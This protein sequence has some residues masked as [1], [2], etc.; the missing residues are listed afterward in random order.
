MNIFKNFPTELSQVNDPEQ[1]LEF[2]ISATHSELLKI[3]EAENKEIL[4]IN[5]VWYYQETLRALSDREIRQL[6]LEDSIMMNCEALRHA[7][8][9]SVQSEANKN[10]S[11]KATE[12]FTAQSASD[13]LTQEQ[14]DLLWAEHT[15]KDLYLDEFDDLDLLNL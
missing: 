8:K 9:L 15:F 12:L 2:T 11:I 3:F 5:L 6:E 13:S 10:V 7:L 14:E 4:K 1:T